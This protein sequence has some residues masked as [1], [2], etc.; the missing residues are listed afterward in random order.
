MVF[1][2]WFFAPIVLTHDLQIMV[3]MIS[4]FIPYMPSLYTMY[5]SIYAL[6]YPHVILHEMF[7]FL[8]TEEHM[9][10]G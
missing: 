2:N 4:L 1:V 5:Y 9:T 3:I 8:N 7:F 10:Y 6:R